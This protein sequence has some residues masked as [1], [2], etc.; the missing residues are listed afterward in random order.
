MTSFHERRRAAIEAVLDAFDSELA[1]IEAPDLETSI[2]HRCVHEALSAIKLSKLAR[3]ML[4]AQQDDSATLIAQHCASMR[5][6]LS[7]E[8]DAQPLP[9]DD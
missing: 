9:W 8:D 7:Q 1:D 4:D 5:A 6:E 2:I 3:A